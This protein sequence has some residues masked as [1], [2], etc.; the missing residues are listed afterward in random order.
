MTWLTTKGK[1]L[2]FFA[3]IS[4]VP[5]STITCA[6][7]TCSS[8][9]TFGNTV[10]WKK[11]AVYRKFFAFSVLEA[12]PVRK[13]KSYFVNNLFQYTLLD[14]YKPHLH[15]ARRWHIPNDSLKEY[16]KTL[17]ICAIEMQPEYDLKESHIKCQNRLSQQ[18]I[19]FLL[20]GIYELW[21]Y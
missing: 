17:M 3:S 11:D 15:I 7:F 8:I 4:R 6:T 5:S 13:P 2:T 12:K 21:Y 9:L 14:I 1:K 20:T 10:L 16:L 19:W 18:T